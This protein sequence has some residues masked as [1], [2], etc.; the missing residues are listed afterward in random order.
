MSKPGSG[1]VASREDSH[2]LRRERLRQ[3]AVDS[4][5]LTRDP[6]LLRNHLGSYECRLCLTLHTN[7]G[8][9]LA[10]TQAKRHQLNLQRRAAKLRATDSAQ[11]LSLPPSAGGGDSTAAQQRRRRYGGAGGGGKAGTPGYRVVKQRHPITGA[12]SLLF[13]VSFPLILPS[14]QPRHRLMSTFEQQREVKDGHHQF[15]LIAAAPYS[16]VAFKVPNQEMERGEGGVLSHWNDSTKHFLL[17]ITYKP[18]T[19][20]EK[21]QQEESRPPS[22]LSLDRVDQGQ[23]PSGRVVVED[24]GTEDWE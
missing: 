6:Y 12:L 8:S 16:V 9:Y 22:L 17:Q 18:T 1:G 11:Q 14:L 3:L 13:S 20:Q 15:V 7:E 4:A 2:I 23:G 19:A 21:G 5:D 24:E 10:H